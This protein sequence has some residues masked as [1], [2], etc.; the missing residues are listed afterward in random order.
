MRSQDELRM[1]QAPQLLQPAPSRVEPLREREEQSWQAFPQ[2]APAFP[3]DTHPDGSPMSRPPTESP[4]LMERVGETLL[5][6][7]LY[8][9]L[10]GD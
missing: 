3:S 8:K 1:R 10:M 9:D 5:P 4:G 6:K 2:P 7:E